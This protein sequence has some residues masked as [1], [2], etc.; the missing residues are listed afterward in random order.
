MSDRTT[1]RS[2]DKAPLDHATVARALAPFGESHTLPADAYTSADVFSWEQ[3]RLFERSWVCVGRAPELD[4]PG[5]RRAFRIGSDGV[6]L[7]RG[8]SGRLNAF[9]NVCRHRGHEL[10]EP[11]SSGRG[12]AI[13]CPYHAWVYDIDGN[14]KGAPRFNDRAGFD[15]GAHSLIPVRV[16]EWRG[17]VFVNVSGDAPAF[18]DHV[19][20]LDELVSGHEPERLRSAAREEYVVEANWKIIIE[21]FHEC[22]HCPSIHPEL[23]R[24]TPPDSGINLEP[25]GAWVG[26]S[27]ELAD[28]AETMSLTGESFGVALRG[29]DTRR[30]RQVLYFGVMPNQLMS[31]HPDYVMTHRIDPIAPD[32]SLVECEWLFAPEAVE[33]AGFDPSYATD[34]WDLTNRQDWRAC[35]SVQRGVSSRGYRPGPLSPLEDEVYKF[36]NMVAR[37][38]MEGGLARSESQQT[39]DRAATAGAPHGRRATS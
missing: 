4:E 35:E 10:V 19:G 37:A 25:H 9:F 21:N 29:L 31:L 8:R 28:T 34:F 20:N 38:Y 13:R 36:V 5:D 11:G 7:V 1:V 27:M 14:L 17:W 3:D 32:R 30:R 24:V 15:R 39:H 18:S 6:L 12:R 33:Q 16:M 26:G 2:R 22:Y 23:C